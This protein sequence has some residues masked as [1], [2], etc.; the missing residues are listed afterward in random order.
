MP[1][2][3]IAPFKTTYDFEAVSAKL[4][5]EYRDPMRE[6]VLAAI[7]QEADIT[8]FVMST[9]LTNFSIN[10]K[11]YLR[12]GQT[13]YERGLP[14]G[15]HSYGHIPSEMLQVAL[16][17]NV[18]IDGASI[19]KPVLEYL[20]SQY[21]QTT[22]AS[23]WDPK[24]RSFTVRSNGNDIKY[25]FVGANEHPT[26]S[27]KYRI[28]LRR[29]GFV[30]LPDGTTIQAY[31]TISRDLPADN[32]HYHVRYHLTTET[33]DD[34]R[35]WT[36]DP[37]NGNHPTLDLWFQQHPLRS[38]FYPIVPIRIDKRWVN[39]EDTHNGVSWQERYH[40]D[41]CKK[42]L[43]KVNIDIEELII[44]VGK[45]E[46]GEEDVEDLDQV[47]DV[48]FQFAIDI[49][50]EEEASIEYLFGTFKH[51]DYQATLTKKE[52]VRSM[53]AMMGSD[54]I[55]S[56]PAP[57]FFTVKEDDSE[58]TIQ[59]NY[60]EITQET[61]VLEKEF[62]KEI[63][64]E[65]PFKKTFTIDPDPGGM[66]D[67]D[68]SYTV[69]ITIQQSQVLLK[70]RTG[71]DTF[72]QVKVHGLKH[73]HY[74]EGYDRIRRVDS[75][76]DADFISPDEHDDE[77]AIGKSAFFIPLSWA[78][79]D[80]LQLKEKEIVAYDA[81]MITINAVNKTKLKWYQTGIFAAIL[82]AVMIA[83]S[84]WVFIVSGGMAAYISATL[85]QLAV[86]LFS[87]FALNF[88]V[89]LLIEHLG[90]LGVI[91][92][93]LI[94]VA[95]A[96]SGMG[97][98]SGLKGLPFAQ[99]LLGATNAI[100]NVITTYVEVGLETIKAEMDDLLKTAKERS[101]DLQEAQDLLK[102]DYLMNPL[103][104]MGT[105]PMMAPEET[106]EVFFE[107]TIHNGNPGV[108]SLDAISSFHLNALELPK[109]ID[110]KDDIFLTA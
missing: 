1:S 102:Q 105:H 63:V 72:E 41:S 44:G 94:A 3:T 36:Y 93:M 91:L 81:M 21:L 9:R 52:Y 104:I 84:I 64:I 85:W 59:W 70:H 103:L 99:Q 33:V 47:N 23:T 11:S 67:T 6:A 14:E 22:Y 18:V 90:T 108:L 8:N 79:M 12:Y 110:K 100:A 19:E 48:F 106:S 62:E 60:T 38:E 49:Y 101:E 39:S 109:T 35:Y 56:I 68:Q 29:E 73:A 69:S 97:A 65:R 42:L 20:G 4:T 95:A 13:K 7:Y 31:A 76:L 17:G 5:E 74:V 87:G 24:D 32:P 57:N 53:N 66:Y 75:V 10:M 16:G 107:R 43:N 71:P 50:T 78:M 51:L 37:T 98:G 25:F 82:Q 55:A 30:I 92:A 89:E 27:S 61:G 58:S 34:T 28:T 88:L 83:I 15:T 54:D 46:D 86:M 40:Y 45:K 96:W 77:H 26:D 80:M 2:T